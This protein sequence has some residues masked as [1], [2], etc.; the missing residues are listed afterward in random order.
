MVLALHD[1][2][3]VNS[4]F[5]SIPHFLIGLFGVLEVS[6]LNSLYNLDIS[7][8]LD[9]GLMEIFFPQTVVC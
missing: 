7:P 8:L 2:S 3:V 6:L 9:V 1:S 4:L 5:R